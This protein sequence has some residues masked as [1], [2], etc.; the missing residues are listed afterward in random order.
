M[1]SIRVSE[2]QAPEHKPMLDII[3]QRYRRERAQLGRTVGFSRT[4]AFP[5]RKLRNLSGAKCVRCRFKL[6][7]V[8]LKH[9]VVEP[10][11][12]A[13]GERSVGRGL[14][15]SLAP[16]GPHITNRLFK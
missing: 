14:Q 9:G 3:G 12:D 10:D 13:D 1:R 7:E 6:R 4:Q 11:Q 2:T 8:E 16:N 5:I 15:C